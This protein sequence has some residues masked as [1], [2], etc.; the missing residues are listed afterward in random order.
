MRDRN[1]LV[2]ILSGDANMFLSDTIS[3]PA[4]APKA[5]SSFGLVTWRQL[6]G[7]RNGCYGGISRKTAFLLK[8]CGTGI[9]RPY[10]TQSHPSCHVRRA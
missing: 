9:V 4:F 2:I 3:V 8:F 6:G 7:K 5:D 1:V 10:E